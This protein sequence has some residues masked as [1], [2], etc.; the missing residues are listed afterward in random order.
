LLTRL[1]ETG[2]NG[3]CLAEIPESKDPI[4]VM[5]YFRSLWLAYQNLL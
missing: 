1:N 3:Y 4:R 2:F 5:K